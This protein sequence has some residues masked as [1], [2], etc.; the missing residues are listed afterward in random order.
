MR[1]DV[2]GHDGPGVRGGLE[3]RDR[4]ALQERG[5]GD[6]RGPGLQGGEVGAVL[7]ADEEHAGVEGGGR[8]QLLDVGVGVAAVADQH[9]PLVGRDVAEGAHQAERVLLR[10]QATDEG[11]VAARAQTEA[12]EEA[13][14][15][16]R[17][18]GH[19]VADVGGVATQLVAVVLG[20]RAGDHHHLVGHVG[21]QG[22]AGTQHALRP[23]APLV[24]LVVEAVHGLHDRGAAQRAGQRGEQAGTQGVV[25]HDV[26]VGA[27]RDE[28]AER[29]VHEGL[30][31]GVAH[32]GQRGQVHPVVAAGR[33]L[34]VARS[35]VDGDVVAPGGQPRGDL[36]DVALDATGARGQPALPDHGD[37]QRAARVATG[38]RRRSGGSRRARGG[39]GEGRAGAAGDDG[40]DAPASW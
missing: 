29:A 15:G 19:A 39:E 37:A 10:H 26:E 22:P 11:D 35:A 36:L 3:Q 5:L 14:V 33:A 31:P 13:E 8:A 2:A 24:A 16:G 25:V 9:E 34:G 30:S 17:H 6:E 7:V 28:C 32:G 4:Q 23:T 1:G 20:E 38:A 21:R 12:G 40:H 18:D 27:G